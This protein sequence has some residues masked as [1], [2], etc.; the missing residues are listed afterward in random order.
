MKK[1]FS[2]QLF[3]LIICLVGILIIQLIGSYCTKSEMAWYQTLN[4]PPLV[5]PGRVFAIVW[6]ILYISIAISFWAVW[7]KQT[8]KSKKFAYFFF[9]IQILFNVI[10]TFFFF[11]LRNILLFLL[12][13]GKNNQN[14]LI[15]IDNTL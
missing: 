1:L 15:F 13:K 6:P 14:K 10:W 9:F 11:Y 3:K 8:E 2:S 5:P 7:I 4:F 12:K